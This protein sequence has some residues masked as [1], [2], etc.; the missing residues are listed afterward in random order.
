MLNLIDDWRRLSTTEWNCCWCC[1]WSPSS[2]GTLDTLQIAVVRQFACP[3]PCQPKLSTGAD[4]R[5]CGKRGLCCYL[6][7]HFALLPLFTTNK[8]ARKKGKVMTQ[9]G[10]CV[11]HYF[12]LDQC[13]PPNNRG[14]IMAAVT[15][16]PGCW[17][18]SSALFIFIILQSCCCIVFYI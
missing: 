18:F 13:N 15:S 6:W 16:L 8:P 5:E 3:L 7:T 9:C 12:C 14:H 11:G 17:H 2:W 10:Q 4:G 1:W